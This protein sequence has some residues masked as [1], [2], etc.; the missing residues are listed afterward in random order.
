MRTCLLLSLALVA[1]GAGQAL[2]QSS[3]LTDVQRRR[4]GDIER[5]DPSAAA[6][7]ASIK[8]QADRVLNDQPNPIERIQTEGKLSSDPAKIRTGQS[9]ADMHKLELLAYAYAITGEE[10]YAAKA[11][12]FVL[13]WAKVNHSAGDPIDDTNLE[14][15]LVA[16]DLMRTTFSRTECQTVDTYLRGVATAELATAK[17]KAEN[18]HNNWHSHRIKMLALIAFVLR[19]KSAIE[20]AVALY[21]DQIDHNLHADGSSYDFHERD[22]LHYHIYD[23]VPLLTVAIAARNS[24]IDLYAYQSPQEAS[25]AKA[26]SFLVPYAQGTKPH[27]EFV[28]SKVAF[29]RK[30]AESGEKEYEAGSPF[31]PRSALAALEKAELFDPS[32]LLLVRTIARRESQKYPTWETVL[33][34][35]R[36]DPRTSAARAAARGP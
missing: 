1:C 20:Q 13:A 10:K 18:H 26:V 30:R 8:Q 6:M 19:D 12:Q 22:A 17:S 24:G 28:N 32:L 29:D 16:Y 35:A 15:L 23:I 31:Q 27:P 34:E 11:R 4:L 33:N 5:A 7:F 36:R 9:L 2:A 25:L 14:P 3:L 21:K